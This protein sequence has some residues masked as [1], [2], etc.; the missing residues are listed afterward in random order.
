MIPAASSGYGL[1]S[2]VQGQYQLENIPTRN[3]YTTYNG[4]IP[5]ATY[6]GVV[7]YVSAP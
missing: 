4:N 6:E 2:A 1:L 3:Y 5:S 7:G